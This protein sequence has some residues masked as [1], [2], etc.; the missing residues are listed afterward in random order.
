MDKK[1]IRV[2]EILERIRNMDNDKDL[3]MISLPKK[4]ESQSL[5]KEVK[6][7]VYINLIISI[8]L[9]ALFLTY[10]IKVLVETG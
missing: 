2:A 5:L 6:I 10:L 7:L 9:L 4:T 8:I 1:D 3:T